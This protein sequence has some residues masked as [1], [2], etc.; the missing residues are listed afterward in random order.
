MES[1]APFELGN[2][3]ARDGDWQGAEDAYRRA[4][5]AGDGAAAAAVGLLRERRGDLAGA[6]DAYRRAD[7]RGDANGTFRLG[8]LLSAHGD[9]DGATEAWRRVDE[10]GTERVPLE[11][12]QLLDEQEPAAEQASVIAAQ[13]GTRRSTFANPVLVGAVT[14]LALLVAV[15]LAYNSNAGLPFVPTRQLKVD[16]TD[17]ANLRVGNDVREGGYLVGMISAMAPARFANGTLGARLTLKLREADGR[18]PVDSRATV[19]SKSVLGFKF[20]DLIKGTSQRDFADGGTMPVSQTTVPVQIDQV[21]DTFDPRTRSAVQQDLVGFG[22]TLTGR[23]SSLNDTLASLPALLQ[24]LRPVA[25]YLSAPPTQ[26]TRLLTSLDTFMR[27]VAPVADVN[28]RLFTDMATTFE[29]FSRDPQAL[30]ATIAKSPSTLSVSTASLKVQQPFLVD[31]AS[32]GRSLTPATAELKAA[33]PDVNPAIEIGTRTLRRTPAL[34]SRLQRVMVALRTLAQAPGTNLALNALV[35]TV[36]TLNPMIRY[37]G[38]YQTVCDDWNYWWTYLSEHLSEATS[39][40]F[41]QRVLLMLANSAELNNVGTQGA[42]GPA[43]GVGGNEFLHSQNYGAAIDN[44]GNADC[45]TGQRGYPKQ[46]NSFDPQ[47]RNLAIDPHTPGDQGPTFH[48]RARLPKGETFSRNPQTGP[49]LVAN[50]SNP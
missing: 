23:G 43:N 9:W 8:L 34:N 7:E 3:L 32:L 38:P 19:Y 41:A 40:G 17:G 25:A 46:L 16:L 50:P 11:L 10:R 29:A 36:G 44:A 1:A 35:A 18:V 5:D 14:V 12:E 28:A 15:F 31:F 24:Y 26:L 48:G 22:D 47:H 2:R 4:D 33:L 42:T 13:A 6:E 37:L 49:Q 27:V 21:F 20:L 45:E 39:F 30:E